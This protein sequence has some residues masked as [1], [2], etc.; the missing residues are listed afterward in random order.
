M[1]LSAETLRVA[2]EFGQK[3]EA[4]ICIYKFGCI[5]NPYAA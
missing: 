2:L 5:L 4:V 1:I 3:E